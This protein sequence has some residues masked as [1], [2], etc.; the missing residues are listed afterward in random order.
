M[1]E[2]ATALGCYVYGVA[3]ELDAAVLA[4]LPGVAGAPVRVVAHE[5]LSALT[6][7]V[8]LGE[9][10]E[11]GLRRNLE[12]LDWLEATA[13]AHHAV[14]A[15]SGAD[16]PVVPLRLATVYHDEDRVLAML[17]ERGAAFDAALHR[18]QGRTEW[19]LKAFL[20]PAARID[21]PAPARDAAA[22]AARPGTAY[23][24]RRQADRTGAERRRQVAADQVEAVHAALSAVADDARRYPPQDSRLSGESREMVLNA[25]YLVRGR[26]R[27]ALDRALDEVDTRALVV[28]WTGPWVPYSFAALEPDE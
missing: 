17:A 12:N 9:F 11:E 21:D 28:R 26:Y 7:P 6:S 2:Q 25:A 14:L 3:R 15:A 24:L 16:H 4:D 20:D 5:G 23:L 1:G 18:V 27:T 10:G 13:R 8:D 22:G 19:G